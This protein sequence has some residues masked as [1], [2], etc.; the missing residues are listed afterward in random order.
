VILHG[1]TS[2]ETL[3]YVLEFSCLTTLAGDH[4]GGDTLACVPCK[5]REQ[6][7]FGSSWDHDSLLDCMAGA[8]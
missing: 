3:S 1:S 8:F 6:R 7:T 2:L 4:E 5:M